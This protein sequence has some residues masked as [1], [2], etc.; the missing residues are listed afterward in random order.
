[1]FKGWQ[2]PRY[3]Q[4]IGVEAVVSHFE[5]MIETM[6]LG[7]EIPERVFS[8]LGNLASS[9]KR[10]DI[11][12]PIYGEGAKCYPESSSAQYYFAKGPL[13][14]GRSAEALPAMR[15]AAR[16]SKK[17]GSPDAPFFAQKVEEIEAALGTK[18]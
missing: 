14:G 17:A 3:C 11:A 18:K 16:L 15:E 6:G 4:R 2:V 10:Y 1:M 13:R 5:G 8:Y 12:I 9:D 7:I